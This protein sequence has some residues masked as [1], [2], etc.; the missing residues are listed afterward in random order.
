MAER[1]SN[2]QIFEKIVH[3]NSNVQRYLDLAPS[4][5]PTPGGHKAATDSSKHP[6]TAVPSFRIVPVQ[7]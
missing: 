1:L 4:L 6:V 7:P 3:T 2:Q 5:K